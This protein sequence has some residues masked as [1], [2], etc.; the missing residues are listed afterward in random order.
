LDELRR[1][2]RRAKLEA[3]PE[4]VQAHDQVESV[5]DRATVRAALASLEP[6][7]RELVALKYHGG[8]S[9]QEIAAVVGVSESNVGT[10]LHRVMEKLRRACA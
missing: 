4:D 10:R 3:D 1:H 2:K 5:L 9:N 6:G 7:E 8:L